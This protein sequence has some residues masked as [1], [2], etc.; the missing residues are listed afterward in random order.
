MNR[1]TKSKAAAGFTLIELLVVIAII[2]I[3]AAILFPV[4]AQAREK[5]RQTSCLSN[6]KQIGLAFVQYVQD[7]DET[8]TGMGSLADPVNGGTTNFVPYDG[9]VMPYI[10]SD[11]VFQCPSD[12]EYD[13]T[14]ASTFG[15]QDGSYKAKGALRSYQYV[16]QLNTVQAGGTDTNTGIGGAYTVPFVGHAMADVDATSETILLVEG[17]TKYAAS[18]SYLSSLS[19][20]AFVGCDTWKLAGRRLKSTA[21]EDQLPTGCAGALG[22]STTPGHAGGANYAMADGSV[23]RLSWGTVRKNDF[24]LF[25]LRKPV[26]TLAP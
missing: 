12:D 20:S 10:K 18:A 13:R 3:L 19:S 6:M 23:K 21:A 11:K 17:W 5:A 16:G 7:Y 24:Y 14:P 4:F 26:N 8:Y 2:A 22:L 25:K 15:Y 1:S 9:L